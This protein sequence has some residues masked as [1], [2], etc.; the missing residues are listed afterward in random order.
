[1]SLKTV[2]KDELAARKK[3]LIATEQSDELRTD[4]AAREHQATQEA[5][6]A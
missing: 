2:I 6:H 3:H 1:M 4:I 5:L